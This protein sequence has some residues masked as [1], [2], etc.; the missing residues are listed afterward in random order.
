MVIAPPDW[1]G[2]ELEAAYIEPGKMVNSGQ[3]NGTGQREGHRSCLRLPGGKGV[4][5]AHRQLQAARLAY[6]PAALLGR[7][8][9]HDLLPEMRHRAG[10]GKR[11]AG[12]AAGGRRV[13]AHRRIAAEI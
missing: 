1:D 11:P 8:D 3:F 12:L 10:A 4:G 9:S 5:Q 7:A 6:L 2:G 13:P